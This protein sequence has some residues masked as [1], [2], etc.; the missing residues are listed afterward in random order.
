MVEGAEHLRAE[1]KVYPL[2]EE[3][4]I[5]ADSDVVVLDSRRAA[6]FAQSGFASPPRGGGLDSAH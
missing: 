6:A 1:L 3:P 5:P 2:F 4:L